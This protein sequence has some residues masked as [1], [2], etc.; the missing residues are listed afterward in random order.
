MNSF[1]DKALVTS[2]CKLEVIVVVI[3]ISIT[4]PLSLII[5]GPN[6]IRFLVKV[7]FS[8]MPFC[9]PTR[10]RFTLRAY[11]EKSVFLAI[12]LIKTTLY[13]NSI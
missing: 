2:T 13:N 6:F 9:D 8:Y 5:K 4:C 7:T 1:L 10:A 3:V 12:N 11:R